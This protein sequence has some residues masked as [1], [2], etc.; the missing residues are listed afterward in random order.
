HDQGD[1]AKAEPLYRRAIAIA[2]SGPAGADPDLVRYL[3]S[4]AVLYQ[5][6]GDPEQ[7]EPLMARAADLRDARLDA[8]LARLPAPRKRALMALLQ[9]ETDS[10]VSLHADSTPHSDRAFEL[11]LTT[12]LRRKGLALESLLDNHAA[13]RANLTPDLRNRLDRLTAASSELS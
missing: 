4:L 6:R 12:V 13:L 8:E 9:Q 10:V 5:A 7:A 2:S 11:A 3:D 1:Y